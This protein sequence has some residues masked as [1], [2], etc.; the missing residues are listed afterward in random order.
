[1]KFVRLTGAALAAAAVIGVSG[2]AMA[3]HGYHPHGYYYSPYDHQPRYAPY[4][5]HDGPGLNFRLDIR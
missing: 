1:M 3:Y 4:G 2:A 5:Y